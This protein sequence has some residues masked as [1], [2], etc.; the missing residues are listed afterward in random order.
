MPHDTNA[1]LVLLEDIA[2][3]NL[4]W[5]KFSGTVLMFWAMKITGHQAEEALGSPLHLQ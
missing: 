2:M 5:S 4:S 1:A 3:H